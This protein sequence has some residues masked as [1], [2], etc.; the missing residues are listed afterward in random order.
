MSEASDIDRFTGQALDLLGWAE[1]ADGSERQQALVRAQ[2]YA[3]LAAA[4]ALRA[5]AD[6]AMRAE[7]PN[8]RRLFELTEQLM[9]GQAPGPREIARLALE[10][11]SSLDQV[12]PTLGHTPDLGFTTPGWEGRGTLQAVIGGVAPSPGQEV[13]PLYADLSGAQGHVA[14][15]GS[16]RSGKST[17]LRSLVA[18]LALTHTPDEAQFYCL[19]LG[20][21]GLIALA[22][23]PHVGG[24]A[25]RLDPYR[26]RRTVAEVAAVMER[27]ERYFAEHEIDSMA[28][29]RR[30]RATDEILGDGF[31]DVFLVVDD[32]LV[33][34]QEFEDVEPIT[35][36]LAE[37]GLG[38]GIH[39]VASANSWSY[40]RT[41]VRT[42][43]GTL[44]ELRLGDPYDSEIDRRLA[45]AVP[46]GKPGRGILGGSGTRFQAA[47]PR[48]D[49]GT[50]ADDLSD[51]LRDLVEA[52]CTGWR[53][54]P[55][56]AVR[57]LPDTLP[58]RALPTAADTGHRVPIGVDETALA[59]VLLDLTADP[60]FVV[61]GD[62]ASGKSNLLRLIAKSIM[63]RHAPSDVRL[64]LVDFRSSLLD[65]AGPHTDHAASPGEAAELLRDVHGV[66]SARLPSAG[67]A[68]GPE[69]FLVVDDYHLVT[70]PGNALAP[71][72][73][74]LPWSKEIGLHL[75]MSAA[76][77]GAGRRMYDPIVQQLKTE[78]GSALLMS[79]SR[80]E[81]T[82]FGDVR[83]EPLPPGRGTY[84]HYREGNRLIQTARIDAES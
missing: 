11:T 28:T 2:V 30:L 54:A 45:A 18:S 10:E 60:H 69:L 81:G 48:I 43:F 17:L 42:L 80:E 70:T 68:K 63:D 19:D 15:V 36:R 53:G 3:T 75:I 6:S 31:G 27:R 55:A 61:V 40:F 16:P 39:V 22:D 34:R 51:G 33:M 20:G 4:S 1:D 67:G 66:L 71:I 8:T 72:A 41:G 32:W 83:P 82:L 12:L 76:M 52:V 74:L 25:N 29:Y 64:V 84:V 58:L 38:Y 24:V 21:G 65:L 26:V 14:V 62:R 35:H 73:E 79:G 56:T 77:G 23:L 9:S 47:L 13:T 7:E 44:L 59:P 57:V 50:S 49:G 78:A 46:M 5:V 37:R